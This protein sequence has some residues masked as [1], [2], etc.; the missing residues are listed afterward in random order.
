MASVDLK[1]EPSPIQHIQSDILQHLFDNLRCKLLHD[2]DQFGNRWLRSVNSPPRYCPKIDFEGVKVREVGQ[3]CIVGAAT[4]HSA[5]EL[6][7]KKF[8]QLL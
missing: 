6:F 7:G 8:F 3:P 2:I 4:D 5:S 1:A